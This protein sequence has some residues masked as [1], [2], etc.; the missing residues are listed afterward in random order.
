MTARVSKALVRDTDYPIT[1]VI[2]AA[3]IS[4]INMGK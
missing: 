1:E 2:E 4:Q 3:K